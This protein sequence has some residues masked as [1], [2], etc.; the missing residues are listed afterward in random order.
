MAWYVS[1]NVSTIN[2]DGETADITTAT[3]TLTVGGFTVAVGTIADISTIHLTDEDGHTWVN[4]GNGDVQI[5]DQSNTMVAVTVNLTITYTPEGHEQVTLNT[6]GLNALWQSACTSHPWKIQ[7]SD[8]TDY[9]TN[10][11]RGK[12]IK[13]SAGA[14]PYGL[15]FDDDGTDYSSTAHTFDVATYSYS[16]RADW[17]GTAQTPDYVSNLNS[18]ATFY[19]GVWGIDNFTQLST[20]TY[21]LTVAPV[22]AA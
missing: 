7:A 19:V 12:T 14:N 11:S 2:Y 8:T 10:P 21:E 20:D 4:D 15:K 18:F 17:D 5:A 3:D 13:D 22:N 1:S 9:S 16:A 6:A